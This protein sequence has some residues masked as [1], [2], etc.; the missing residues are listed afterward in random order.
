MRLILKV[1]SC[2]L[3]NYTRVCLKRRKQY[4]LMTKKIFEQI[5]AITNL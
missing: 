4:T 1:E 3:E 5:E 2:E